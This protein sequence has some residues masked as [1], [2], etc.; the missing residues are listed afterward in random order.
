[1][2][3]QPINDDE[4]RLDFNAKGK[5]VYAK[6]DSFNIQKKKAEINDYAILKEKTDKIEID[7][8]WSELFKNL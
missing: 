6:N 7:V 3:S 8:H 4:T 1:M 5:Y 2:N